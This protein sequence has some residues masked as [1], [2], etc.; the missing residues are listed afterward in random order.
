MDGKQEV[1]FVRVIGE[2][3]ELLDVSYTDSNA[4]IEELLLYIATIKDLT[5]A[6]SKELPHYNGTPAGSV[7]VGRKNIY[8]DQREKLAFTI[9]L[10]NVTI[11]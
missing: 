5:L 9:T 4:E 3:A 1:K 10:K 2:G 8:K 6:Q 7:F 11:E